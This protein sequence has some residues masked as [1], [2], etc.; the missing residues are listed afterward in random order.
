MGLKDKI[1][2]LEEALG[3]R[4]PVVVWF[5]DEP[6]PPLT[7]ELEA[8]LVAEARRKDP[9]APVVFVSWPRQTEVREWGE[10]AEE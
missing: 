9:H 6:S 1:Q 3:E 7:P 4:E 8:E 10:D 2:R 5:I